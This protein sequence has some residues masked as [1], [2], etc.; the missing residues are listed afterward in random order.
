M[1]YA[2]VCMCV[3]NC[4]FLSYN[5]E[6][7]MFSAWSA[8]IK[9]HHFVTQYF[10]LFAFFFLFSTATDAVCQTWCILLFEFDAIW[11]WL[12]SVSANK[13]PFLDFKI[14]QKVKRTIYHAA[15][16]V[17]FI[18]MHIAHTVYGFVWCV[19]LHVWSRRVFPCLSKPTI[20][21]LSTHDR[22]VLWD[23]ACTLARSLSQRTQMCSYMFI[24]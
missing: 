10:H 19:T 16:T 21:T 23:H 14:A 3:C 12:R 13:K 6:M 20:S 4:F 15:F 9:V 11:N 24:I 17:R 7:T 22:L 2:C 18:Q 5:G 8:G 1:K